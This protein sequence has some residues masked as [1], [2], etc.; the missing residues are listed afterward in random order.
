MSSSSS[1]FS[2]L[3]L[4][5]AGP[6]WSVQRLRSN[7]G[8]STCTLSSWGSMA[9]RNQSLWLN[10]RLIGGSRTT[11]SNRRP[12]GCRSQLAD[13][14]PATSAVYGALLLGGGLFACQY[15]TLFPSICNC[16]RSHCSCLGF[17]SSALSVSEAQNFPLS[18]RG[19]V[20]RLILTWRSSS[21][22]WL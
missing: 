20:L 19:H 2:L 5:T 12:L 16:S 22:C 6:A 18:I 3:A 1:V 17:S 7:G 15:F 8:S 21:Y 11:K 10:L 4:P 13:L 14:A 9:P